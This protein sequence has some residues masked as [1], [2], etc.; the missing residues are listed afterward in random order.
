MTRPR[1]LLDRW[2]HLA[3][4][5]ARPQSAPRVSRHTANA[6][7]QPYVQDRGS[8]LGFLEVIDDHT[9]GFAENRDN[10]PYIFARVALIDR[11]IEEFPCARRCVG[12]MAL[13]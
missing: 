6:E 12:R 9:P 2:F 5:D 4:L 1:Q 7:G 3:R 13:A 8:P 11:S 10:R